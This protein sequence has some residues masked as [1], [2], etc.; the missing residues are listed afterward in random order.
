MNC[1]RH[2]MFYYEPFSHLSDAMSQSHLVWIQRDGKRAGEREISISH[3]YLVFV[4]NKV[5]VLNH[6]FPALPHQRL[7][8]QFL[9]PIECAKNWWINWRVRKLVLW[10]E[11]MLAVKARGRHDSGVAWWMFESQ[12]LQSN[13]WASLS[14]SSPNRYMLLHDMDLMDLTA[15]GKKV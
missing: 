8:F 2:R 6:L 1:S 15:S 10:V 3:T 4:L 12:R 9:A 7:L 11:G 14:K 13:P 5:C